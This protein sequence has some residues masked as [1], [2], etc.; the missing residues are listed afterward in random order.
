M[1]RL[2]TLMTKA[3]NLAM[4]PLGVVAIVAALAPCLVG[5]AWVVVA[6]RTKREDLPALA[7]ALAQALPGRRKR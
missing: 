2:R 5:V 1:P 6:I 4:V 3:Y 7:N